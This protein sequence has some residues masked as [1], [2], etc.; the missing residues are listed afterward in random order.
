MYV[1]Y[2]LFVFINFFLLLLLSSLLFLLIPIIVTFIII[3]VIKTTFIIIIIII[4]CEHN[5]LIFDKA[6]LIRFLLIICLSNLRVL[7][8]RSR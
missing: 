7:L 1:F 3:I 5:H 4:Y 8:V 6:S 2:I